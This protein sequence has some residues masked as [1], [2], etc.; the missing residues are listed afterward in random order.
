MKEENEELPEKFWRE[1]EKADLLEREEK[2]KVIVEKITKIIEIKDEKLKS[3][4]L[5]L[6]LMSY[7]NDILDYKNQS[8]K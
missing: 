4:V 1:Y 2:L 6:S 8:D 3:H 7:F 5:K